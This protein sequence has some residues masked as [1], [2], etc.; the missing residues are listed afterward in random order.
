MKRPTS[1]TKSFLA[2]RI[3]EQ[4]QKL[5]QRLQKSFRSGRFQQLSFTHQQQF[6][7]QLK[8]YLRRLKD[9]QFATKKVAIGMALLANLV[10]ATSTTAQTYVQP[11]C[12]NSLGFVDVGD[13]SYPV[14]GDLNGDGL[15]D[16]IIGNGRG[17]VFYFQNIGS[18][19]IPNFV[20]FSG[21]NN[22]FNGID[23]GNNATP[24]L[25]DIDGDLDLD[26]FIGNS[27]GQIDF[28]RNDGTTT[29]PIFN[30]QVGATNPFN[31]VDVGTVSA[32]NFVDIDDDGDLDAFIPSNNNIGGQITFFR[33]DGGTFTPIIG[34]NNPF[35]A[36]PVGANPLITFVDQDQDGDL[37]A[38]VGSQLGMIQ[39]YRNVGDENNPVYQLITGSENPLSGVDV[40]R[41][42]AL[43]PNPCFVDINGD[44]NMD[45]F[46]GSQDGVINYF[47]NDPDIVCDNLNYE[48]ITGAENPTDGVDVGETADPT[49]VDIDGDGDQ[50]LFVGEDDGTINFFINNGTVTTPNFAPVTGNKNPF[51]GVD[52]GDISTIDFVD[53]N[54]D[55]VLDAFVGD[56]DGNVNFF[57]NTGTINAPTFQQIN[58]AGNPFNGF[59]AGDQSSP[60]FADIDQDGDLDAFI[61]NKAGQILFFRNDGT[62]T[63]P[64]FVQFTDITNPFFGVDLEGK[65]TPEFGDIDNDGD[66]DALI[67]NKAGTLYYFRNDGTATS[68]KF[69]GLYGDCN[70]FDNLLTV[71][72]SDEEFSSP[73]LVDIDNDGNLEVFVGQEGGQICFLK[74]NIPQLVQKQEIPTMSQWGMM[75][76]GLLLLN[77]GLMFIEK[78]NQ[79]KTLTE[80]K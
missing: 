15:H 31:G 10:A 57:S 47:E 4:Y 53:I 68:P 70:P 62:A 25:V 13:N 71:L 21:A 43:I 77:I 26:A 48:K 41:N 36:A 22:P 40:G 58:G 16:V 76:F 51:D 20:A 5:L 38:F 72:T 23:V 79:L 24:F 60:T 56:E 42:S 46:I 63:S 61:G 34:A 69:V 2:Q 14:F 8:K 30:E 6:L 73:A 18:A 75:I 9:L 35:N 65:F 3:W 32:P 27:S 29:N 66:L 17:E 78:L 80:K 45:I 49:F 74:R 55:G 67:G 1:T 7:R 44:G 54:A 19:T 11:P 52:L 64:N 28:Y 59:D 37:D 12:S 39:F 33:N 50:D